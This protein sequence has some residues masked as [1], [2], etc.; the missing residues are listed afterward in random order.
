MVDGNNYK[1]LDC[2]IVLNTTSKTISQNKKTYYEVVKDHLEAIMQLRKEVEGYKKQ[3]LQFNLFFIFT[4]ISLGILFIFNYP[5]MAISL[6][7]VW[8]FCH[9]LFYSSKKA[10]KTSIKKCEA[11]ILSTELL[12][13]YDKHDSW[14]S[15]LSSMISSGFTA[16]TSFYGIKFNNRIIKLDK[17]N[18][19]T[20]T[21]LISIN[22]IT[23][24]VEISQQS[25]INYMI[26]KSESTISENQTNGIKYKT[27]SYSKWRFQRLDGGPDKRY[28]NN[29]QTKYYTVKYL[30]IGSIK[31]N[32]KDYT[33]YKLLKDHFST[34]NRTIS[35]TVFDFSILLDRNQER[36]KA[37]KILELKQKK[38]IERTRVETQQNQYKVILDYLNTQ[39][40]PYTD[41]LEY[42]EFFIKDQECHLSQDGIITCNNNIA[43]KEILLQLE[44]YYGFD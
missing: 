20:L 6:L 33:A 14:N 43:T 44:E 10:M 40:I 16:E 23:K 3:L 5:L 8:Q 38:E 22:P 9:L 41:C 17:N 28:N 19:L 37:E 29:Y 30:S 12:I 31:E 2:Q 25:S 18:A 27:F 15:V 39:S 24:N 1:Y 34:S 11:L 42:I 32:V 35:N 36:A 7:V 4:P 13:N 21:M 26:K